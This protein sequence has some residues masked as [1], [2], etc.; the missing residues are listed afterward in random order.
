MKLEQAAHLMYE[1]QRTV[2]RH[3]DWEVPKPWSQLNNTYRQH[4]IN[5]VRGYVQ[6]KSLS[7]AEAHVDWVERM[8]K[9]GWKPGD[10]DLK[11][12]T[13][14]NLI[15]YR[16]LPLKQRLLDAIMVHV[17]RDLTMLPGLE[18]SVSD[19]EEKNE[20]HNR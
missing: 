19:P 20:E 7:P 16:E 2:C 8:L 17:V 11:G 1:I 9:S 3:L 14:P 13:L 5:K 18:E 12:K 10:L 4:L 6:D 15:S